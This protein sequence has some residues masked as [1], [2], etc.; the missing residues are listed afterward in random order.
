MT[1]ATRRKIGVGDVVIT[2]QAKANVYEVLNN[3]RLTYGPYSKRFEH[4]FAIAHGRAF[5]CFVNS[6]TDA[7]RIGLAA[8]KEKYGWKDGDAVL[9]PALTFVASVNV[10]LQNKLEPILVDIEPDYYAMNPTSA[11]GI[12]AVLKSI[13]MMPV[14]MMPVHLFGQPADPE[15]YAVARKFDIRVIAD[16]CETMFVSGCAEGDVSCFSTYACHVMQTGVG[17]LATTND[18]ELAALIRSYANHGRSGMYASIDA[19]LGNKETI[20][21]RFNFE[22]VGYSSRATEMEAAI[23]CA[24]L[25]DWE[26]NVARRRANASALT[27][28]LGRLPLHL[29][30]VRK[31]GE[32]SWMMYPIRATNR[33]ERDALVLHLESNGIET[34][35]L[36]PITNQP[37]YKQIWGSDLESRYPVARLVNETGFYVGCHPYITDEEIDYMI[38]V[39]RSFFA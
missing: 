15:L 4:E 38:S 27:L 7:L 33:E 29:P 1:V 25:D 34:R 14:A 16:S 3:N 18:P 9:V 5:A 22:R 31:G 35:S 26:S 24:E 28:G 2:D 17:G 19:A 36:M 30:C 11:Q 10:I 12:L 23:G 32:S 39:F 21:A 37:V 8:M 13:G 6:G 20:D